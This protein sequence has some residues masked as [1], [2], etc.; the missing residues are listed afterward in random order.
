MAFDYAR[1]AVVA[2]QETKVLKALRNALDFLKKRFFRC[3]ALYLLIVA[4]FVA[5][6]V[7]FYAVF[8]LLSGPTVLYVILAFVWM[9]LHLFFR[10]WVK[11]LFFA[12]Q[13]EFYRSHPY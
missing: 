10:I 7:V 5:G 1:I 13:A 2:D 12:A 6:T 11:T 9:Q 4:G 8:G 3:W